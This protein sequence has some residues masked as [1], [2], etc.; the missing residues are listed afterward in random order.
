MIKQIHKVL[1]KEKKKVMLVNEMYRMLAQSWWRE[2]A[3]ILFWW[4]IWLLL[5]IKRSETDCSDWPCYSFF[6]THTNTHTASNTCLLI[7]QIFHFIP[8]ALLFLYL[9]GFQPHDLHSGIMLML[10][11]LPL[12]FGGAHNS[13]IFCYCSL[14]NLQIHNFHR[15]LTKTTKAEF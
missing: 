13:S 14:Q 12:G 6:L 9:K 5:M 15:A 3:R 1:K 11:C 4:W 10:I 8:L 7:I 2:I